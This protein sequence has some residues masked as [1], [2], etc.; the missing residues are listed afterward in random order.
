MTRSLEVGG[1]VGGGG[2]GLNGAEGGAGAASEEVDASDVG[3]C[4]IAPHDSA[5]R[6]DSVVVAQAGHA[7]IE[8]GAGARAVL[9][10]SD[11]PSSILGSRAALMGWAGKEISYHPPSTLKPTDPPQSA[12]L[13]SSRSARS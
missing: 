13:S 5:V 3:S 4:E 9:N 10:P 7:V 1:R 6:V 2:D 11:C 8:G 12:R